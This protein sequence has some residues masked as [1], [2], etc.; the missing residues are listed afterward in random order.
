M[1]LSRASGWG[2]RGCGVRGSGEV[3]GGR[4]PS[5]AGPVAALDA[6]A[7]GAALPD[8]SPA[9]GVAELYLNTQKL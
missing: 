8:E 2:R 9:T 1:A 7:G 6:V 5:L 4:Y 3:G